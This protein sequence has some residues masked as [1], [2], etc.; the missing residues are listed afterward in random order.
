MCYNYIGLHDIKR[1][2]MIKQ[3]ANILKIAKQKLD[4]EEKNLLRNKMLIKRKYADIDSINIHIANIP[5]PSSGNFSSYKS[6]KDTIQAYL[7]EIH[8]I[9]TQIGFLKEEQEHIKQQIRTAVLEYEKTLYLYNR[10]K[11]KQDVEN[12]KKEARQLDE[13]TIMLHSRQKTNSI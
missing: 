9:Q 10:A 5:M 4:L 8:E 13:V 3:L 2:V 7:F 11:D 1:N 6:K 12:I